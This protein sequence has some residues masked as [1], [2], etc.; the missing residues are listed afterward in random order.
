MAYVYLLYSELLDRFYIGHTEM[1]PEERLKKHLADHN[2]FTARAN[3]WKLV[4]QKVYETKALAY[5]EERRLKKMKSKDAFRKLAGSGVPIIRNISHAPSNNASKNCQLKLKI[6][7]CTLHRQG[8]IDIALKCLSLL[9]HKTQNITTDFTKEINT[10]GEL[11]DVSFQLQLAA[12]QTSCPYYLSDIVF[13]HKCRRYLTN[14]F[15][16]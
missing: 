4:Y 10:R 13:Y 12:C 5:A 6:L 2:G 14:G 11:G 9:F 3:D 1:A 8:F 7:A 16:P 15:E